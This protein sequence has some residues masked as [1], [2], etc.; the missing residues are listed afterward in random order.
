MTWYL[1]ITVSE[2]PLENT[3][4]DCTFEAFFTLK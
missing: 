1:Q 3:D 2:Q 4:I